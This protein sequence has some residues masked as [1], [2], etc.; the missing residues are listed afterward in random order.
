MTGEIREIAIDK[1]HPTLRLVYDEDVILRLCEDIEFRGL[2][3]PIVV[4]LVEYWF[5]IV[6]GE[7]RWR[8]CKK[9]GWRKVKALIL[10]VSV[11]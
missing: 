4:E 6:D 5:Q 11:V 9:M 3:E 2:Q 10:E 7:K 8:A 1:I